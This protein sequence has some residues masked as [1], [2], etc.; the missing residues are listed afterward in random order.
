MYKVIHIW[1]SVIADLVFHG[2]NS[3]PEVIEVYIEWA[4]LKGWDNYSVVHM[5]T[6][7]EWMFFF[8]K[9]TNVHFEHGHPNP[10]FEKF[11]EYYE[12]L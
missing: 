3:V 11:Q 2:S 5:S 7:N 12:S 1:G 8:K 4:R 10:S 9:N 6:N